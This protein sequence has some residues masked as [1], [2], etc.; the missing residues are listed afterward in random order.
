MVFV[1][2]SLQFGTLRDFPHVLIL[3]KHL[4]LCSPDSILICQ[5][6]EVFHMYYNTP[7]HNPPPKKECFSFAI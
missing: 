1:Y 2:H 5:S 3:K 6:L 4:G 7:A